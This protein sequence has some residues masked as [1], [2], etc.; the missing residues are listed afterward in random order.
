[1]SS[2]RKTGKT[3]QRNLLGAMR[4]PSRRASVYLLHYPRI[5]RS[6]QALTCRALFRGSTLCLDADFART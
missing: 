1:M 3:W 2:R 6:N 5:A 4:S